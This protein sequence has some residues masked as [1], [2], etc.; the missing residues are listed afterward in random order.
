MSNDHRG[1][2]FDPAP[3]SPEAVSAAGDRCRRGAEHLD[4]AARDLGD[5][6]GWHGGAA[7]AFVA[8]IGGARPELSAVRDGLLAAADIL[9]DWADTLRAHR[10]EAD[11]LERRALDLRRMIDQADDGVATATRALQVALGSATRT[12]Q[13]EHAVAVAR[14]SQLGDQLDALLD[15][16]RALEDDHHEAARRVADRLWALGEDGRADSDPAPDE[17]FGELTAAI[18]GFSTRVGE[19]AVTLLG[20]PAPA[21]VA[22]ASGV[23][24]VA[25]AIPRQAA[26]TGAVGVFAG[27]LTGPVSGPR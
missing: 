26:R 5:L 11:D 23:S 25:G 22:E 17:L 1:L 6:P 27:A 21:P 15:Q 4:T 19:M 3:G 20:A 13:A 2:G 8:R 7:D 12:A 18:G 10:R 24:G 14:R 9:D 16:A